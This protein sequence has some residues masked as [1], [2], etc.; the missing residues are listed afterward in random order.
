MVLVCSFLLLIQQGW[1]VLQARS[2]V[3]QVKRFKEIQILIRWFCDTKFKMIL[4]LESQNY[5][6]LNF[7]KETSPYL[8]NH[9]SGPK[10]MPT[11]LD[12]KE[13]TARQNHDILRDQK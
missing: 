13:R 6:I 5:L 10:H 2:M 3:Y 1:H 4:N 12:Q 8:T 7:L 9:T 11:L